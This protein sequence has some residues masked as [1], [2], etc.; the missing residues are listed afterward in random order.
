MGLIKLKNKVKEA[1]E[2]AVEIKKEEM[3]LAVM[4]ETE[5][6]PVGEAG[7]LAEDESKKTEYETE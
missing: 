2:E 7:V 5:E 1:H 4:P 3:L 6:L